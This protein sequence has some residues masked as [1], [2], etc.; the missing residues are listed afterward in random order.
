[1]VGRVL[2]VPD[3]VIDQIEEEACEVSEKCYSK[4]YCVFFVDI[5]TV[6]K[7]LNQVVAL[8]K[9]NSAMNRSQV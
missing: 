5:E 3:A 9:H 8:P 7:W 6:F 2:K 1:M 4:C